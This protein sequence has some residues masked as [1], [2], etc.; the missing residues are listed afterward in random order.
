MFWNK[1]LENKIIE[2]EKEISDLRYR[3]SKMN[4]LKE[5]NDSLIDS[6]SKL[7]IELTQYKD[8][9]REQTEA[10]IFFSCS[11]IQKKLMDGEIK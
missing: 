1:K 7:D 10:D 11:K 3:L 2:Q 9:V 8:K 5:S 6:I 4:A